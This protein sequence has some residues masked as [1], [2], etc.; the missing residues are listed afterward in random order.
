MR[1]TRVIA[2]DWSGAK[3]RAG[4]TIWIAEVVGDRLVRLENGRDRRAILQHLVDEASRDINLVIGLDFAFSMPSWFLQDRGFSCVRDL[5]RACDAEGD[6]WLAQCE[7]PFWGRP[8]KCRPTSSNPELRK[9]D[10]EVPIIAGVGPK[11][12]FQIGG[13]G[14]V[15][16]G[17]IRGMA[18]LHDLA[19]RGFSVWPFDPP[20]LPLVLEIYPRLFT[21][22]L[23]KSS[24]PARRGFLE[25]FPRIDKQ[26]LDLAELSEDAFDAAMSAVAMASHLESILELRKIADPPYVHEGRIWWPNIELPRSSRPLLLPI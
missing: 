5:W 8:G 9:T 2:I 26:Y 4:N 19:P 3:R 22:N 25:R 16:T 24:M 11:S 7:P 15:G 12:V 1:L 18:F 21:P 6:V 23:I 10:R 13:A 17:S 14:A 20:K